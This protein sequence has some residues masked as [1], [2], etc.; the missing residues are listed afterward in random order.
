MFIF[1]IISLKLKINCHD[2]QGYSAEVLGSK[3][4]IKISYDGLCQVCAVCPAN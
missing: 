2:H 1:Y 3:P 4:C